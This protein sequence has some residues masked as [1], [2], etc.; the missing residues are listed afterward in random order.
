MTNHAASSSTEKPK[1]VKTKRQLSQ[2]RRPWAGNVLDAESHRV[3][4]SRKMN[5]VL[6][7]IQPKLDAIRQHLH[8]LSL[9]RTQPKD[10]A[11][12]S[13][14]APA[15]LDQVEC[16]PDSVGVGSKAGKGCFFVNVG[17]ANNL[18]KTSKHSK[19]IRSNSAICLDLHKLTKEQALAA[20]NDS[21]PTWIETA[22]SGMYP[23]VIRVRIACSKGSQTLSEVVM[24]WINSQQQVAHAPKQKQ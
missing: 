20:L 8:D 13:N 22:N 24:Q 10:K 17:E 16:R 6:N 3:Q 2:Q 5:S 15:N 21:L 7:E 23:F 14:Q 11:K 1:V 19:L 18:Y 12:T 9:E 4:H